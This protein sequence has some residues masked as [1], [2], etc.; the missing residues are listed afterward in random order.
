[1]PN[2]NSRAINIL[3]VRKKGSGFQI[4]NTLHG[5]TIFTKEIH[6]HMP[7]TLF[8][9]MTLPQFPSQLFSYLILP[10][11]QQMSRDSLFFFSSP[12]EY[13]GFLSCFTSVSKQNRTKNQIRRDNKK[14]KRWGVDTIKTLLHSGIFS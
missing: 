13:L 5:E 10:R 2:H 11:F 4:Q 1:M 7:N 14:N 12:F 9:N 8:V 3:L 6:V